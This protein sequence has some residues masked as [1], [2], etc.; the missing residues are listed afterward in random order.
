MVAD[1]VAAATKSAMPLL[2]RGDVKLAPIRGRYFVAKELEGDFV[3]RVD[4]GFT[5]TKDMA[6]DELLKKLDEK[7]FFARIED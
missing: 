6:R 4:E 2:K 1:L 3:D 7:T 5:Y